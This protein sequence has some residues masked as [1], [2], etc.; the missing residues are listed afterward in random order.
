M[1]ISLQ[2]QIESTQSAFEAGATIAHFHVRNN[3]QTPSSD[4]EKFAALLEG[5][6][7][8]CPGMV[9]QFSTGGRSGAGT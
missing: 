4:P 8:H 5:L 1:P 2:E 9:I 6:K 3:D 7:E